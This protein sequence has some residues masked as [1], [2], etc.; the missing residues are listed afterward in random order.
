MNK[1]R[2]AVFVG[3]SFHRDASGFSTGESFIRFIEPFSELYGKITL[4]VR[5]E[6]EEKRASY[7]IDERLFRVVALPFFE[8]FKPMG[9]LRARAEIREIL[10]KELPRHGAVWI[11]GPHLVGLQIAQTCRV[12]DL[13][14]FLLIRQNLVE[15]VRHKTRGARRILAMLIVHWLERQFRALARRQPTFTVGREMYYAYGGRV[16][17]NV[18]EVYINLLRD[19]D[20]PAELPTR[21]TGEP[22]RLLWVG[23]LSPEKG[24]PVLFEAL[25]GLPAGAP[26]PCLTLVGDGDARQALAEHAARLGLRDRV[27]FAGYVPFGQALDR[28]YE[29]ADLFVLPSLTGEGLPQ[30]L[31]EAMAA[32]LPCL[33]SAVEGIP[34]LIADAKNGRIVPPGDP[35]ALRAALVECMEDHE[36]RREF[37]KA[38]LE[39]V[40]SHSLEN[41]RRKITDV[42]TEQFDF[43]PSTAEPSPMDTQP[44]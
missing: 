35:D 11:G 40:R 24:L 7:P 22:F 28:F 44:S 8:Q 26:T 9:I 13:P 29:N 15:Q 10:R 25:A 39:T 16:G 14:F 31:L 19:A 38:G 30:V 5:V 42:L 2:L 41:E 33:A 32:G 43:R 23:R 3:Q 18:H 1:T 4:L 12:L 36:A 6:P 37:A 34:Y 17:S 27:T 20:I 21:P